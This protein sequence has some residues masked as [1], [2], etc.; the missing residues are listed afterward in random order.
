[1]SSGRGKFKLSG[2]DAF[3][4]EKPASDLISVPAQ[5][6]KKS[7]TPPP[8]LLLLQG[9][10]GRPLDRVEFEKN[11]CDNELAKGLQSTSSLLFP[12]SRPLDICDEVK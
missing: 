5:S 3:Y 4:C 8:P 10:G 6:E 11:V 7:L 1:M 2:R 9:R 12:P